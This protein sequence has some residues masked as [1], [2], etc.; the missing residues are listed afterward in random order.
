MYNYYNVLYMCIYIICTCTALFVC[1]NS[2]IIEEGGAREHA[3]GLVTSER[4]YHL[5]A[6]TAMD[7][8]YVCKKYSVCIIHCVYVIE[9]DYEI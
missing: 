2:G 5:T 4:T 7:K 1:A 3:F 6:E 8:K 9:S